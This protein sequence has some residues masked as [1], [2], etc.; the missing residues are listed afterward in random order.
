MA[1]IGSLISS[2]M[3]RGMGNGPLFTFCGAVLI[4]FGFNI[5][6]VKLRG[7]KWSK[8]RQEKGIC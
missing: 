6:V 8:A 4:L 7:P 2:D 1:G 5:V 3:Q